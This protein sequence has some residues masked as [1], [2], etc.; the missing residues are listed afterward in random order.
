[1]EPYVTILIFWLLS[2]K[3]AFS[4][5]FSPPSRGSLVPLCFLPFRVVSSAYLRLLIFLRA[6]LIPAWAS[7]SPAFHMMYSACNLNKQGEKTQPWHTPFPS[8]NQS[9]IPCCSMVGMPTYILN[10]STQE[11]PFLH[12][13]ARSC[14]YFTFDDSH[15]NKACSSEISLWFWFTFTWW[16]VILNIFARTW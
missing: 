8:L 7:S 5:L 14:Y 1:M 11:F 4:L 13:F 6:V 16:L 10:N 9:V 15:S 3:L 12:I 2:F